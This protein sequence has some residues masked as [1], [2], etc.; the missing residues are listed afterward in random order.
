M[1][2][3]PISSAELTADSAVWLLVVASNSAE[4]EALLDGVRYENLGK[5]ALQ[6]SGD[7]DGTAVPDASGGSRVLYKLY[8]ERTGGA[9]AEIS[10]TI[11]ATVSF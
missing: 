4:F 1:F 8:P 3:K 11:T 5:Y 9:R 6:G 2:R 10:V 7:A